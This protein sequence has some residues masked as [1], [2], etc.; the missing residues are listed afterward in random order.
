MALGGAYIKGRVDCASKYNNAN[1]RTKIAALEA[2]NR[3]LKI[4]T[5]KALADAKD[6][7]EE[8]KKAEEIEAQISDGDCFT[9]ADAER[10]RQLWD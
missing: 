1:L 8:I 7:T 10:V 9:D 3:S 4:D 5:E 2:A 6:L